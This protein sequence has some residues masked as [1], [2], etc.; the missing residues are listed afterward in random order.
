MA[1]RRPIALVAAVW[2]VGMAPAAA[3]MV[4]LGFAEGS[5]LGFFKAWAALLLLAASY[6][7]LE[8]WIARALARRREGRAGRA[9]G[10]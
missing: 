3:L 7:L 1:K 6:E 5:G 8:A 2:G 10:Q 4:W 9:S